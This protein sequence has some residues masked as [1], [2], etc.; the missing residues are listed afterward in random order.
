[1]KQ[2]S[3]WVQLE[4]NSNLVTLGI[5]AILP[6]IHLWNR[7]DF[8]VRVAVRFNVAMLVLAQNRGSVNGVHTQAW[9]NPLLWF[10]FKVMGSPTS[11]V[12]KYGLALPFLCPLRERSEMYIWDISN[13]PI[14]FSCHTPNLA[15]TIIFY[16]F[17]CSKFP[18]ALPYFSFGLICSQLP[19]LFS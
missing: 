9:G 18:T 12:E 6:K 4:P 13:Q 15:Q 16:R 2:T 5:L 11:P 17:D 10:T 8:Y 3:L 7:N 1:M 19:F 14:I